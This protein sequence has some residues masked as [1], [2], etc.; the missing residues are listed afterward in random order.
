MQ[1]SGDSG[2]ICLPLLAA[3]TVRL[4]IACCA[5]MQHSRHIKQ[6][7]LLACRSIHSEE[8]RR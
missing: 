8:N 2:C 3:K 5:R 6:S 7:E 1:I 4:T